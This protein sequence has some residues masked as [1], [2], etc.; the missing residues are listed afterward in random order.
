MESRFRCGAR[1]AGWTFA[2]SILIGVV[3]GSSAAVGPAQA[4]AQSSRS[5]L[6]GVYT[7]AQ[8]TRGKVLYT[9]LC[10]VCH[11]DPPTGTPMAPGLA[12]DDFLAS[13]NGMTAADLFAKI[14]KT[15]PA[16]DP[17]TLKPQGTA[18][19]IAF[20][21]GANKWPE[22]GMELPADLAAL[23]QIRIQAK[24]SR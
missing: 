2:C 3:A 17:G 21:F 4:A 9:Q 5:V 23:K 6:D 19:L 1:R 15:M 16:D 13:Y 8:A 7:G 18:D 24:S 20:L 12:G 14:S 22:G 11:G 10:T